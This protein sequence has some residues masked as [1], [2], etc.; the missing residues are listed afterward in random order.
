MDQSL[1]EFIEDNYKKPYKFNTNL[2]A[3]FIKRCC[4]LTGTDG[5]VAMVHP[6]TFMYIKT[7][8]DVR[9]FILDKTHINLFVEWGYLGM[10]HESARVD[11][12]MYVLDKQPKEADSTFIKLNHI[13]EGKRYDAF[14]EAYDDLGS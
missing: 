13:Y 2:Y 10:F 8:A 1:R 3:T 14:V 7:F 12:S 5:K 9:K 4:E 6:P 11:A